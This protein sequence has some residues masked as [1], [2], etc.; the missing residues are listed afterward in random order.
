MMHSLYPTIS[1][2]AIYLSVVTWLGDSNCAPPLI[3]LW[4][5]INHKG[6]TIAPK[7]KMQPSINEFASLMKAL[8]QVFRVEGDY[9]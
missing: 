1:P 6:L 8:M 2:G 9:N 7:K 3:K 5:R 4:I